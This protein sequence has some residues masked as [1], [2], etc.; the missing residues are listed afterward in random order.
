MYWDIIKSELAYHCRI[1]SVRR[2]ASRSQRSGETHDFHVIETRDWVNVIPVTK[3]EQVVMVRQF[4]HGIGALTLE[5][6][7]GVMDDE[8]P[9]PAVAA[10]RELREETGYAAA[11]LPLGVVHPNPA[12]MNNRCHVFAAFGVERIAEPSLDATEELAVETVPLIEIPDLIRG[13]AISNALTVVAFQ[14]LSLLPDTRR[15]A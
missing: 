6:P 8:D 12:L 4:R 13:G 2:N 1:F 7:A 10:A 9:S 3:D 14:L 5:V 15:V 11:V